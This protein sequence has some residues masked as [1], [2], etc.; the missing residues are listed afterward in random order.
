MPTWRASSARVHDLGLDDVV[1]FDGRYLDTDELALA[2]RRADVVVLPYEST[3]QVT[4]GVLVE[5]MAAGKPVVA[6]A[7]PHA[8]ELLGTGAG[9]VVPHGDPIALT[10][11]LTKS[12]DGAI[13]GRRRW[14]MEAQRIGSTL[15]WPAIARRYHDMAMKLVPDPGA[16]QVLASAAPSK[17]VTMALHGRSEARLDLLEET[18]DH[19]VLGNSA[20]RTIRP[21]PAPRFDHLRRMT[22]HRGIWEHALITT[23]RARA[24]LLH[25]RQ[26]PGPHR[27][28][29]SAGSIPGPHRTGRDL[30]DVPAGSAASRWRVSQPAPLRHGSWSDERDRTTP[31]DGRCG[32]SGRSPGTVRSP[33]CGRRAGPVRPTTGISLAISASECLRDA[34]RQRDP[35]RVARAIATLSA[36]W[37]SASATSPCAMTSSGRGRRSASPTTTPASRRR[38]WPPGTALPTTRSSMLACACSSGWWQPKPS[39]AT[40]AS[41]PSA[42]WAP[43]E[44]RPGFDQQPVEAAAM[45]DACHRA[46]ALTGDHRWRE[47]CPAGGRLVRGRQ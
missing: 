12:A 21:P 16:A 39:M 30:S 37:S 38:C 5:A 10:A 28:Q 20:R 22:D 34:R 24:R 46:W 8:V 17:E 26:R 29:P 13:R 33:G 11:A 31:R 41:P 36:S 25:R 44:P 14:R 1:E 9:I 40:S 32:H 7:F 3:E 15:Q 19:R 47:R 42:G 2:V 45:A 35:G 43:G 18:R 27:R 6:T 23:P 4:S